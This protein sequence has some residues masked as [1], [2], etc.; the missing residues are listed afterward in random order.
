MRNY[1]I[2]GQKN[3][4]PYRY[5]KWEDCRESYTGTLRKEK[6]VPVMK[7]MIK[8]LNEDK[9]FA[10]PKLR[11]DVKDTIAYGN[12]LAEKFD[13]F[14]CA[15]DLGIHQIQKNAALDCLANNYN[16]WDI[17]KEEAKD[18]LAAVGAFVRSW[19]RKS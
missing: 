14:R 3:A 18:L 6:C 5:K 15:A 8:D 16:N 11:Y 10:L 12:C 2:V 7:G 19:E 1:Y 4:F 17:C 13:G 9:H